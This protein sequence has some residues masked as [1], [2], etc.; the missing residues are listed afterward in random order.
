[1]EVFYFEPKGVFCISNTRFLR[2]LSSKII[3]ANTKMDSVTAL[4]NSG[5]SARSGGVTL[6]ELIK[7]L[8]F[9]V[10]KTKVIIF[11]KNCSL[12]LYLRL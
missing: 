12:S 6:L 11:E 10:L 2:V 5:Y 7:H 9:V 1:M 3:V 8:N 4:K